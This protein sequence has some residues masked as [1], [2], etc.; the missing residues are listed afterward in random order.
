MYFGSTG[1]PFGTGGVYGGSGRTGPGRPCSAIANASTPSMTVWSSSTVSA[2]IPS[3]RREETTSSRTVP[4]GINAPGADGGVGG[5]AALSS[6]RGPASRSSTS[7]SVGGGSW[8]AAF[9]VPRASSSV[10][11]GGGGATCVAP[12]TSSSIGVGWLG[13]AFAAPC[14]PSSSRIGVGWLGTAFAVPRTPTSAV[15][16]EDG[17]FAAAATSGAAAAAAAS[18]ARNA[19]AWASRRTLW[20]RRCH[21]RFF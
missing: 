16:E 21:S 10:G 14:L 13:A 4:R 11:V 2:A 18:S 3:L 17:A 20:Y 19:S 7:S 1:F 8:G 15:V 9:A 5:A 6:G 12:R